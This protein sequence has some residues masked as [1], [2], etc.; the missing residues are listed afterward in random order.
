MGAT[1]LEQSSPLV[2]PELQ[3][4]SDRTD[5]KTGLTYGIV[6][7]NKGEINWR[8]PM[9]TQGIPCII[10]LVFV[11]FLP[12]SPRWL[13]SRGRVTEAQEILAK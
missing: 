3:N 12:E 10:V 4:E 7:D 6:N 11:W 8:I 13:V 9:A 5:F 1:S 2:C